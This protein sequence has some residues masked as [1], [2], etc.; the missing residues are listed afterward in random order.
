MEDKE[1]K[2]VHYIVLYIHQWQRQ[3]PDPR[4]LAYFDSQQP[5]Y[6]ARINGLE[7]AKVYALHP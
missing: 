6:V 7:Y 4:M 2:K 5:V 3:R 1:L